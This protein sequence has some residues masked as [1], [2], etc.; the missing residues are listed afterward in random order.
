MSGAVAG[1][2]A[3][4]CNGGSLQPAGDMQEYE[5]PSTSIFI[6]KHICQQVRYGTSIFVNKFGTVL[7]YLSTSLVRYWYICQQVRYGT[8]IFISKHICQQ[9][10]YGTGIFVNKCGTVL[11]YLSA[12][13]FVNKNST[14]PVPVY[15]SQCCGSNLNLTT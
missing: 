3:A 9:V 4:L 8:G 11:V 15:L 1:G 10:R 13:I 12:R 6:S 2:A 5:T 14:V 7:V